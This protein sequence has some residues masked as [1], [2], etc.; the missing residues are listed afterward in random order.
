MLQTKT[1]TL[2]EITSLIAIQ[3]VNYGSYAGLIVS[4][5]YGVMQTG[6]AS[7]KCKDAPVPG[8]W[9]TVAFNDSTWSNPVSESSNGQGPWTGHLLPLISLEAKWIW[10]SKITGTVHCRLRLS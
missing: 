10:T 7:W 6:S 3:A 8:D 1:V 4:D 2:T 9:M 5:S